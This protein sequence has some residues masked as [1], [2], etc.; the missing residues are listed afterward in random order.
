MRSI[1]YVCKNRY[2]GDSR[3]YLFEKFQSFAAQLSGHGGQP[4][5]IP[6]R[7]VKVQQSDP[8]TGH[9]VA[10]IGIVS[11]SACWSSES[12]LGDWLIQ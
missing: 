12:H 10:T 2:P 6:S 3:N 11:W 1:F 8:I 9:N 7:V 4:R 5:Y